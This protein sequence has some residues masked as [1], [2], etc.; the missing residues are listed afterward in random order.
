ML[1]VICGVGILLRRGPPHGP[2]A[3]ER[4]VGGSAGHWISLVGVLTTARGGASRLAAMAMGTPTIGA[5]LGASR[6]QP[7]RCPPLRPC[8]PAAGSY[9][10]NF[11]V[12][13]PTSISGSYSEETPKMRGD[14]AA[15]LTLPP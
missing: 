10:K 15:P 1:P 4:S 3:L 7:W 9:E 13:T 2:P 11:V 8:L 5:F 12:R 14:A 6:P